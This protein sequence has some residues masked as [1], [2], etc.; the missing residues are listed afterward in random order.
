MNSYYKCCE[1]ENRMKK[2]IKM[3]KNLMSLGLN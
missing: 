1:E 3:R 2:G